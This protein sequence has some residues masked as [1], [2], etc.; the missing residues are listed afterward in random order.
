MNP[1]PI[2]MRYLLRFDP[3][4]DACETLAFPCD[5]RGQVNLDR[6]SRRERADYLFARAVIGGRFGRPSVLPAAA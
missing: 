2:P 5:E 3:L 6:L 1:Q 4:D